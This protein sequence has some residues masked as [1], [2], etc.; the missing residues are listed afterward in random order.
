MAVLPPEGGR[1]F[2][3]KSSWLEA[4]FEFRAQEGVAQRQRKMKN[5]HT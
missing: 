5:A 3:N 1:R 2:Y 4:G